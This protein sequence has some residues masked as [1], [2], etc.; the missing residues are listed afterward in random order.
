[1]QSEDYIFFDWQPEDPEWK[2]TARRKIPKTHGNGE[3]VQ[4]KPKARQADGWE[5]KCCGKHTPDV[6]V[7]P[8]KSQSIDYDCDLQEYVCK[9][10]RHRG[11]LGMT[12]IR[13]YRLAPSE[14]SRLRSAEK[15]YT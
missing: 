6:P 11:F 7:F 3:F 13:S 5:N 12:I 14:Y 9:A 15:A 1:M 10:G 4:R 8:T 2:R